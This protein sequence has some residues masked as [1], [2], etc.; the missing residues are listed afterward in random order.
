MCCEE[1]LQSFLDNPDSFILPNAPQRLP[2][3]LPTKKSQSDIKSIFP[4]QFEINGFCSVCY[5]DGKY[6]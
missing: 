1:C 5:S 3:V 6:Q 2:S 4:K